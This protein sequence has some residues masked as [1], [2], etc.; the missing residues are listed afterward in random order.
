MAKAVPLTDR[1]A[2][3]EN[4]QRQMQTQIPFGNDKQEKQ[5]QQEQQQIIFWKD[6]ECS[7]KL[8]I[9]YQFFPGWICRFNQSDLLSACPVLELLFASDG[10]VDVLI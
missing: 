3:K 1:A 9:G 4:K 10:V 6:N 5:R 2:V 7:L 8:L